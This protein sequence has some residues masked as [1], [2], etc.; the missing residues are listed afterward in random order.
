MEAGKASG[1]T[2]KAGTALKKTLCNPA[3]EGLQASFGANEYR[4]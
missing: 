1:G 2:S 4:K 3:V